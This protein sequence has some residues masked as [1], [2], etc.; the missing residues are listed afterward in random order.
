MSQNKSLPKVDSHK[1]FQLIV[2]GNGP[3]AHRLLCD[4]ASH[5]H[6]PSSIAVVG[7]EQRP[8]YNRIMLS[9]LLAEEIPPEQ[10]E[11][12]LPDAIL[13]VTKQIVGRRV[14]QINRHKCWIEDD[15]GTRYHYQKLVF[16]TGASPVKPSLENRDA[17]GVMTFRNTRDVELMQQTALQA[18]QAIVVG[19]GFLGLE[20]A[21]GLRKLGMTVTLL[22]R[23]AYLLNRQLDAS[24]SNLLRQVLEQRGLDIKTNS[25]IKHI[26]APAG[27]VT[28]V[29][30][31]N[32]TQ[33]NADLVVFALGITP[34]SEL[35]KVAGMATNKGILVDAGMQTS[36]NNIY[37]VGECIEFEGNTYGLV[38]PIWDQCKVLAARL[39]G[40]I[41]NYQDKP[42]ATQLKIS[43]I[44][45]Y[46]CGDISAT[47]ET[48]YYLDA[49]Q[50]EYRRFW[51]AE[52]QLVGAILFGNTTMSPQV[53]E[54]F[55]ATDP[56]NAQA[57]QSLAFG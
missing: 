32:D 52:G 27:R 47:D 44:D 20:A 2:I 42:I 26:H 28:S 5:G 46:S 55:Q 15:Q 9:P 56:V 54:L 31:D 33:L 25:T 36:D 34:N 4:L 24:A 14:L 37:A 29:T 53:S 40:Q 8:A 23:S 45:L 49:E 12:A 35:A 11:L 16:A 39:A 43:G 3:A 38:A 21:E 1:H 30:L 22:H 6:I 51:Y 57:S 18:K 19:G 48:A 10:I 50:Q 7:E 17:E 41:A 13:A